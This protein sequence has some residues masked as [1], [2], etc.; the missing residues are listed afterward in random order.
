M[1]RYLSASATVCTVA[2]VAYP[3]SLF[4]GAPWA[5]LVSLLVVLAVGSALGFRSQAM[6]GAAGALTVSLYVLSFAGAARAEPLVALAGI[7]ILLLLEL[8]EL[9]VSTEGPVE[10]GLARRRASWILFVTFSGA[11]VAL[12]AQAAGQLIDA[13]NPLLFVVAVACAGIALGLVSSLAFR[14]AGREPQRP[15]I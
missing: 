8:L 10:P 15:S 1:N 2:L 5:R 4:P 9:A 3:L 13:P 6:V 7:G 11:V 12:T 14:A